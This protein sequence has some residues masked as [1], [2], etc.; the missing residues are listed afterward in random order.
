MGPNAVQVGS[1]EKMIGFVD[2]VLCP[3]ANHGKRKSGLLPSMIVI[4]YTGMKNAKMALERLCSP[5]FEVSSHYLISG[6]SGLIFF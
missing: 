1:I 3:S 6:I 4:H 5:E 2:A